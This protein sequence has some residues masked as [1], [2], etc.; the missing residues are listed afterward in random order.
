MFSKLRFQ[1]IDDMP[2]RHASS[3]HIQHQHHTQL[4]ERPMGTLA[5]VD[6]LEVAA[7]SPASGGR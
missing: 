5:G 1:M 2:W 3:G 7:R 4:L 6:E